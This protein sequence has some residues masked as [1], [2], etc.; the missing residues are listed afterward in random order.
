MTLE[1][2]VA[3]G[4]ADGDGRRPAGTQDGAAQPVLSPR[5]AEV[6]RLV[7][8][9]LTNRQIAEALVLQESTVG[10]HLQRIYT[11]LGLSGRAHLAT[12]VSEQDLGGDLP[13]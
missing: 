9:G 10:N 6:A 1:Q 11:R 7:A 3:Y 5:E 8:R 2:A 13:S 12:W 4:L